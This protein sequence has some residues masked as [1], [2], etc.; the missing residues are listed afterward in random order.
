M[1]KALLF[2]NPS[3][4]EG[5][6]CLE[7][8]KGFAAQAGVECVVCMDPAG[9]PGLAEDAGLAVTFGGDGAILR[10]ARALCRTGIPILGINL[11]HKGF[12]AELEPGE[13]E[14]AR[15]AFEGRFTIEER[16][17][18][19]V[20]VFRDGRAVHRDFALNEAV[21]GGVEK[22]VSV[23]VYGDGRR[24]MGFDGDGV[25]VSTPTGSTAYSLSAG[26]PIVEPAARSLIVTPVCPHILSAR[27][28]VLSPERTVT[29]EL[30]RSEGRR[31][32]LSV[33]GGDSVELGLSDRIEIKRSELTTRLARVT[34]RSFY[35]K[36][37]AKLGER[38]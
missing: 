23:C 22:V 29:V 36:V 8:V 31:A 20:T 5:L 24:I 26:G 1:E 33:D 7:R 18:A 6:G 19:D 37:A 10:A 4:D 30:D 15:A 3:R 16:M 13:I 28:Y 2:G 25:I 12:M 38:L 27:S 35:E 34:G 21:V 32:Y 14:A 9:L 11:G 17:M